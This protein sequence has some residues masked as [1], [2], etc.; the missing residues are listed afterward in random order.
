MSRKSRVSLYDEVKAANDNDDET[1]SSHV[2]KELIKV[3][4]MR[5][6]QDGMNSPVGSG[7]GSIHSPDND[8]GWFNL[9]NLY[10]Q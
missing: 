5:K 1:M 3:T 9:K 8:I 2:T 10:E 6:V 7:A 4:K